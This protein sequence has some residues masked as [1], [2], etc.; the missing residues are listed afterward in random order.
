MT[1]VNR[2]THLTGRIPQPRG[3]SSHYTYMHPDLPDILTV[4][5][6]KPVVKRPYVV[7]A[8][9]AVDTVRAIEAARKE[10]QQ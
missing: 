3:G 2:F 1:P 10:E 4:P 5:F 6:R 8:L 9:A 7:R